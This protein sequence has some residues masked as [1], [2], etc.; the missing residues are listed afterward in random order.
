VK[1]GQVVSLTP[2]DG[3]GIKVKRLAVGGFD[4]RPLPEKEKEDD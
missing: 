3:D 2:L 1:A 4:P